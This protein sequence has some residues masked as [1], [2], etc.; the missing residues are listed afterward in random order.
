MRNKILW[1]DE[2]NIELLGLN[3]KHHVWRKPSTILTVK[4][5][6]GS[7]MLGG[8]FSSTGAGRLVRINRK[9]NEAKCREIFDENLLQSTQDFRL[10]QRSTFQQNNDAKLTAKTVHEWLRD[11]SLNVLERPSQSP[12]L[13]EYLLKDMIIAV[14]QHSPSNLTGLERICREE[15]KKFRDG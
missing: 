14:L 2:T 7:T 12:D 1:S 5:C 4:H 3:S 9:M 13:N 10:R 15:W 11:E 6:C 8:S